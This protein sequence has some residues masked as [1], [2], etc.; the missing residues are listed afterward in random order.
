MELFINGSL[1][2]FSFSPPE[3]FEPNTQT[4]SNTS[5]L[6]RNE[7]SSGKLDYDKLFAVFYNINVM[8]AEVFAKGLE[9]CG[10]L[11]RLI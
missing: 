9:K 2:G 1:E 7:W 3:T 4:T 8:N 10:L 6:H 11:T 5:H